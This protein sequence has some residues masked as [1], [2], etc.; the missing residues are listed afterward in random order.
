MLAVADSLLEV[1]AL[2]F[3]DVDFDE[4]DQK[5]YR[6]AYDVHSRDH[7]TL[8]LDYGQMGLGG[9]TSWGAVILPQYR[10]PARAYS[11]RVRLLP[12]GPGDASPMVLSKQRF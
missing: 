8:D 11:Y 5:T 4:G 2:H 3:D 7:V 10:I 1:S 12:F 6:H 9:D